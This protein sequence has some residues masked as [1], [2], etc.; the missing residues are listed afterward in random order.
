M[1]VMQCVSR[2][3][4]C[5]GAFTYYVSRSATPLP[6]RHADKMLTNIWA[7]KENSFFVVKPK[8]NV[9]YPPSTDADEMLT[10][11][12]PLPPYPPN[13]R[14]L[15]D[16]ICERSLTIRIDNRRGKRSRSLGPKII[17]LLIPKL[18]KSAVNPWKSAYRKTTDRGDSDGSNSILESA[19]VCLNVS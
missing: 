11:R 10:K 4:A 6:W 13:Q 17:D 15:A 7:L 16:V 3:R 1:A 8:E 2:D 12:G 19:W 5:K 9:R 14:N 18:S